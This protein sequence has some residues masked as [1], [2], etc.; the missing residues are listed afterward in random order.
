MMADGQIL[1]EDDV[2]LFRVVLCGSDK[3]PTFIGGM[4]LI[5]GFDDVDL[6]LGKV[7]PCL[8]EG[9]GG[10]VDWR[11]INAHEASLWVFAVIDIFRMA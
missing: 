1:F 5:V 6:G 10:H 7:V 8:L 11:V 9:G 4:V 3:R 2:G